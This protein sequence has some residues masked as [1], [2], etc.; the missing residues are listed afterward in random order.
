MELH[1]PFT[2]LVGCEVAIQLSPMPLVG[3][4]ELISAVNSAG[5]MGALS[6]PA[7]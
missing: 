3:T 2:E 1:T 7:C 5:G 6:T 4:S